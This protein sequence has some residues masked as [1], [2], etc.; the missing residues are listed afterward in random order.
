VLNE[1]MTTVYE[2]M[3]EKIEFNDLEAI[4]FD[5]DG[6]L[7]DNNV[8]VDQY[9]NET[10]RCN[11]SDGLGF[12]V[13]RLMSAKL[14]ILSTEENPVVTS[15]GKKIKVR[16]YQGVSDKVKSLK[17]LAKK[18]NFQLSKTLYIGNDLNDYNAMQACGYSAC[19]SDSHPRIL[20]KAKFCLKTKGGQGVVREIVEQL[21]GI[22]SLEYIS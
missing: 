21:L 12:D 19:P 1:L 11:R 9:G 18:E 13:L 2:P 8:F 4:V 10:V 22:D 5:F 16:V 6:V 17:L 3:K 20:K 14:F 7:T 15:R